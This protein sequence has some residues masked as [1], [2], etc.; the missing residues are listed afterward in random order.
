MDVQYLLQIVLWL[1]VLDH[2]NYCR[3]LPVHIID[4]VNL[5]NN[6]T[7]LRS[8]SQIY[9][10]YLLN[11]YRAFTDIIQGIIILHIICTAPLN[12]SCQQG[13]F[14]IYTLLLLLIINHTEIY[15]QF[16]KGHF[17]VQK[18]KNGFSV[19]AIDKCHEQVN[20]LIK[21]DSGAVGLAENP[22]AL[23]YGPLR[24]R[25]CHV[26]YLNLERSFKQPMIEI[27][28][29]HTKNNTLVFKI[30]PPKKYAL[31]SLLLTTWKTHTW[32]IACFFCLVSIPKWAKI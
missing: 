10:Y 4:M 22:Q 12:G 9:N 11:N 29:P 25:R 5:R 21:G 26:P 8:L 23:K 20:E 24:G 27:N 14:I 17:A 2:T 31:W 3:W 32:K 30:N 18:T 16:K 1:F 15:R 7:Y 13:R 6:H 28:P 19:L